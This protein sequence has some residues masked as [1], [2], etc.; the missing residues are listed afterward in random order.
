MRTLV[1]CTSWL[2][3]K[4]STYTALPFRNAKYFSDAPNHCLDVRQPS[5]VNTKICA[6]AIYGYNV[7]Y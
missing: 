3:D 4:W 2:I 5:P 6:D 7:Y 1:K